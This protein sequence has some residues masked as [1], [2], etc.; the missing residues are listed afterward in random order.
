V[1]DRY[2]RPATPA[3]VA[4][5]WSSPVPDGHQ[6]IVVDDFESPNWRPAVAFERDHRGCRYTIGP[7]H[8]TC[9]GRPVAALARGSSGTWWVYCR[10]HLY[11]RRLVK[12]RLLSLRLAPTED[13]S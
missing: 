5:H 9:Q 7:G 3:E 4:A 12:G 6:V 8:R 1:G 11:G 13:P 10:R 2:Q